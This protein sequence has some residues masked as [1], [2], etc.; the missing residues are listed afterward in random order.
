MVKIG[1]VVGR[2]FSHILIG[3][4]AGGLNGD[5]AHDFARAVDAGLMSRR[6]TPPDATYSFRHAL[7]Q[8]TAY[9]TLLRPKR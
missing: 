5:V 2:T 9:D 3:A 4:V 6:G 7:I 8:D 1:A